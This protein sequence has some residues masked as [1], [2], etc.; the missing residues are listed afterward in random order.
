MVDGFYK[1]WLGR[2]LRLAPVV[3]IVA[4]GWHPW[5]VFDRYTAAQASWLD[6]ELMYRCAARLSEDVLT[7]RVNEFGTINVKGLCSGDKDAYV[8][9]HELEA[10][11]AGTMEFKTPWDPFDWRGSAIVGALWAVLAIAATALILIIIAIGRWVWG[12]QIGRKSAVG[13]Q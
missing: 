1:R 2:G 9:L 6:T 13:S 3:G 11:R 7:S 10:V 8:A 4:G 5:A 12:R